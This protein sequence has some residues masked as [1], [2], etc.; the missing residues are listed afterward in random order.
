MSYKLSDF[1]NVEVK[2]DTLGPDAGAVQITNRQDSK[3]DCFLV[4]NSDHFFVKSL[5]YQRQIL[6]CPSRVGRV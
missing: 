6:T 2:V 4:I 3:N 5:E 1:G